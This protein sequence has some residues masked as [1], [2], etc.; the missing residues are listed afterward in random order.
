MEAQR[1]V[2]D[3]RRTIWRL[4]LDLTE[5]VNMARRYAKPPRRDQRPWGVLGLN[6]R[7]HVEAVRPAEAELSLAAAITSL[8]PS[9]MALGLSKASA[10]QPVKR[11]AARD[12]I[13]QIGGSLLAEPRASRRARSFHRLNR[14]I[15]RGSS[16]SCLGGRY[17]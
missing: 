15:R 4:G 11:A 5:L 10:A 14:V 9:R 13:A 7:R 8:L 3:L 16:T 17:Q 6:S 1:V 2:S 12:S